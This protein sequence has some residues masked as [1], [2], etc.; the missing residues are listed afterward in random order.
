MPALGAVKIHGLRDLNRALKT[1]SKETR[2]EVREAEKQIAEPVRQAAVELATRE[3]RN[4]GREWSQMRIGVTTKAIYIA[5]K[6]RRKQGTARK[7]LAS[8]LMDRAME[9]ALEQNRHRFEADIEA[10]LDRVADHFNRGA[11]FG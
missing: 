6:K 3:I 11:T 2:K 4:I 8:L 10:A 1:A 5:P 9:P 7:N